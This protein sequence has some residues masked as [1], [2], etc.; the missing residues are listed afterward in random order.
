MLFAQPCPSR[1]RTIDRQQRLAWPSCGGTRRA[2]PPPRRRRRCSVRLLRYRRRRR[3]PLGGS[4]NRLLLRWEACSLAQLCPIPCAGDAVPLAA[5]GRGGTTG[6][7]ACPVCGLGKRAG[8]EAMAVHC[9]CSGQRVQGPPSSGQLWHR[10]Q[11][12]TQGGMPSLSTSSLFVSS[13]GRSSPGWLTSS[14]PGPSCCAAS[15]QQQRGQTR[16]APTARAWKTAA[17]ESTS[18]LSLRVTCRPPLTEGFVNL[19]VASSVVVDQAFEPK[20]AQTVKSVARGVRWLPRCIVFTSSWLWQL[21]ARPAL[22]L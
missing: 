6:H 4:W 11:R 2:T 5:S 20:Q 12:G 3:R 15:R 14:A 22:V 21:A 18:A 1:R 7:R 13:V 9:G 16:A 19:C 17:S 8:A 10:M